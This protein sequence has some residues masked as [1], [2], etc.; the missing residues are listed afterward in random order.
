MNNKIY[1]FLGI[2][3]NMTQKIKNLLGII[4]LSSS[5]SFGCSNGS[6][7]HTG[8]EI[9]RDINNNGILDSLYLKST[10]DKKGIQKQLFV[11]EGL[12]NGKYG[13]ENLIFDFKNKSFKNL[14][15]ED[16]NNDGNIDI[17][18][19]LS[20]DG[21]G[22]DLY[23]MEGNGNGTFQNP[24]FIS[25]FPQIPEKIQFIDIDGDSKIDLVYAKKELNS[26]RTTDCV[27]YVAYNKNGKYLEEEIL[28]FPCK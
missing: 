11:K 22:F 20:S 14:R 24:D 26:S 6:K 21:K 9:F 13:K 12:P 16:L 5:L 23:K 25:Y 8:P 7:T 28:R 18:F 2:N 17:R 19:Y 10:E 15:I 27:T 3:Y 1:K 4:A